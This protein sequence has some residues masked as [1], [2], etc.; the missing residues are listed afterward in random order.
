MKSSMKTIMAVAFLIAFSVAVVGFADATDAEDTPPAPSIPDKVRV[1]YTVDAV[2]YII[3]ETVVKNADATAGTITLSTLKSTV[4]TGYSFGGW[5]RTLGGTAAVTSIP[6]VA[7]EETA[8]VYAILI[9]TST[10]TAFDITYVV[11]D[12]ANVTVTIP[13]GTAFPVKLLEFKD[14]ANYDIEVP[15]E[16]VFAGWFVEGATT[17]TVSVPA[18]STVSDVTVYAKYTDN[19]KITVIFDGTESSFWLRSDVIAP[20]DPV[21]DGFEFLGWTIN[22]TDLV[23]FPMVATPELAK[24]PFTS[25][26][27]EIPVPEPEPEPEPVPEPKDTTGMTAMLLVV[28]VI[29][30]IGACILV[31]TLKKDKKN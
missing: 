20:T 12:H 25:V 8:T 19:T 13:K 10:T 27:K 26:F 5:T 4:P 9:P 22:G 30:I 17:A 6:A 14:F 31:W 7:G 2:S 1:T 23:E 15:I 21:K 18:S 28:G 3:E 29:V 24:T 16:K 11:P